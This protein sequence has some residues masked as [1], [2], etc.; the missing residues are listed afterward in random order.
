MSLA[1]LAKR[2]QNRNRKL[3]KLL[4]IT[5]SR[6]KLSEERHAKRKL[7]KAK[8]NGRGEKTYS[9]APFSC[10]CKGDLVRLKGEKLIQRLSKH[11][12]KLER[13]GHNLLYDAETNGVFTVVWV[14]RG[15]KLNPGRAAMG[16]SKRC[17][18]DKEDLE[19]GVQIA[20]RRALL[21]YARGLV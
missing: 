19:I 16:I 18:A 21:E 17:Y 4:S 6:L 15:D 7:R 9:D 2:L 10:V 3:E 20:L 13:A 12:P 14:Y 11:W 1:D 8:L 5:E